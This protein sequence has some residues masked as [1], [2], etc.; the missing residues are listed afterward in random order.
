MKSRNILLI[1][2][3]AVGIVIVGSAS[4]LYIQAGREIDRFEKNK[5]LPGAMLYDQSG[6]VLK[7]L[8]TGIVFVPLEQIPQDLQNA[9]KASQSREVGQKLGWTKQETTISQRL[10]GQILEPKDLW[11]RLKLALLPSVL[12]KRYSEQERIEMYLNQAY[13]G[14]GAYGVEAASQTYFSKPVQ[15]IDLAQSALLAGLAK[16]AEAV[17]PFKHPQKAKDVR[18]AI[19]AQ[20][21]KQNYTT[22]DKYDQA[23]KAPI[24]QERQEPGKAHYFSDYLSTMLMDKLGEERV[25]QGGLQVTTTLDLKLQQLAEEV[26]KAQSLEGALVVLNPSDGALLAMVGGQ[27]YNQN[28][29][30]LATTK[31]KEVGTSLRPL[32]YATGLKEGWAMNHLVEDIQRKFGDLEVKNAGDRYWGTVT[33]KH[34]LVLDLNNAALWTLDK[35]GLEPFAN[36]TQSLNLI[37]SQGDK[38]LRLALGQLESGISLLELTQA[39]L[40]AANRGVQSPLSSFSEVK[41]AQ[42]NAVLKGQTTQPKRTLSE[43]Q[44]Y[45]LAD[46]LMATTDYGTLRGLE[47]DFPAAL[48]SS[49]SQDDSGQWAIGYTP[50]YLVGVYLK[51]PKPKAGEENSPLLA[52]QLWKEFITKAQQEGENV[53]FEVP[54]DV[55]TGVLIDVFTGLLGSERC[56]QVEL[57]AF[58]VGTKPTQTAPCALPPPPPVTTPPIAAP[59]ITTP[60]QPQT[61]PSTTPTQPIEPTLPQEPTPPPPEK[62]VAPPAEQVPI[63]PVE[64][65]Q[66]TGPAE[67]QPTPP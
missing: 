31:Q 28:K 51:T 16:E 40:G 38:N 10:A 18:D 52:A 9:V 59:P 37:L 60:Q 54:K 30:N 22:K 66:P 39:Y 35:L 63:Q 17:S 14:E 46:M 50:T 23:I 19:L 27:N 47:L 53:S 33:A 62:P 45:L 21:Q 6:T 1:V 25:F 8:G 32:I 67:E 24:S 43:Q 65:S 15:E 13:F 64:P 42:N 34:A 57:D 41:D 61:P 3:L 2:L 26:L 4:S 55:E 12:E 20:M 49:V 7:R 44:A 29:T 48:S 5:P 56:P 58:I 36:F 11:A